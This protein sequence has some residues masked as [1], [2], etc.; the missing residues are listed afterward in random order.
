MEVERQTVDHDPQTGSM[1]AVHTT[2]HVPSEAAKSEVAA[3]KTNA[4]IWYIVGLIDVLLVLRLLFL[5]F[6]ANDT[7][8]V[9]ILY[10]VTH[11]FIV[12][13]QGIFPAPGLTTGYFDTAALLAIAA[14]TLIGWGI[15]A[16]IDISKRGKAV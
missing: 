9:S 4:Y 13:F 11:P 10:A 8:V 3:D 16:L 14:Y 12:L 2:E 1:H 7:G 6:G 5:L 15:V